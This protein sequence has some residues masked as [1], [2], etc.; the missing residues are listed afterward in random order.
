MNKKIYVVLKE[1]IDLA[2]PDAEEL[3]RVDK[4]TEEFVM[5]L[6]RELKEAGYGAEV[7]IGGSYAKGTLI[8]KEQ[9]D[10]DVFVRFD[11]KY[12]SISSMLETILR[13]L[14]KTDGYSL[15]ILH[16]SRDYFKVHVKGYRVY[17]EVIPVTKIKKPKEERNVTD[18]SY[19]H[20]PY[21]RRKIKG[22][23]DQ[24]RLAKTFFAAQKVYGAESYIQGF[25]G[26]AVECLI[27]YYRSFVKMLGSFS[28]M[29]I[30]E[31]VV[32]DIEKKYKKKN[33]VFFELNESKLQS[34]IILI[35]PTY[36]E[37]NALASLSHETFA[38]VQ[39]A[40]RDFLKKPR[41]GFFAAQETNVGALKKLGS[42][43]GREFLHLRIS[44]DKQA[45]DIAGTKLKK[46]VRL[47]NEELNK[48]F[49][50]LRE[51]FE[52]DEKH[53]ADIYFVLQSRGEIIRIGPPL[54]MKHHVSAFKK[55]HMHTYEKNK[56]VHAVVEVNFTA[57]AYLDVWMKSN[58]KTA[59]EMGITGMKILLEN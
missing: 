30:G 58:E 44:T 55:E 1:Q 26:Y 22:L 3:K 36:K 35:D 31:R 50:I 59:R 2:R 46:F 40:G 34:Q 57:R 6:E 49:R 16:G 7:F 5:V 20:V 19:F 9:Y 13:R 25:S 23:Q 38:R 41:A 54:F 53:S 48:Y 18:L 42:K 56:H 4:L 33:D 29:K 47:L 10:V 11:W 12:D 8:R 27:I 32:I 17:F 24:V 39:K 52:Y 51:E 37:R 43:G 14:C 28:Q 45:G 21:V 15:E